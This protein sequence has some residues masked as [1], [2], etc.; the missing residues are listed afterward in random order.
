MVRVTWVGADLPAPVELAH[1]AWGG[2]GGS[3][4]EEH[5][6]NAQARWHIDVCD[7][8]PSEGWLV[9]TQ[10]QHQDEDSPSRQ[11]QLTTGAS[12]RI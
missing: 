7:H 3:T 12:L 10:G 6:Q 4:L 11:A 5:F 9:G 8:A 1:D 2:N